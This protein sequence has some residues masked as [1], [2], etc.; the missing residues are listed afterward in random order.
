MESRFHYN[1][2]LVMWA[3]SEARCGLKWIGHG[4]S[5]VFVMLLFFTTDIHAFI[6]LYLVFKGIFHLSVLISRTHTNVYMSFITTWS[7]TRLKL[8]RWSWTSGETPQL[9][10][11][12]LSWTT[13][14]M[15]W[16]HS[17]SWEPPSL[18]T[19]SGTLTS[20]PLWKRPSREC[21]FFVNW[22]SSTC[23]RRTWHS[24]TLLLLSRFCALL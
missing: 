7:S 4:S 10:P 14:W 22:K 21:T 2:V 23:H 18:R 6:L 1:N 16:S 12:S 19:W 17:G 5:Q 15:Q 8:W 20:T 13:L 24:F 11:H 9:S 3:F